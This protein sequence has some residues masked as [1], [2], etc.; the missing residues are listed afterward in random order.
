ML[1]S[2]LRAV[3]G[4]WTYVYVYVCVLYACVCYVSLLLAGC[5]SCELVAVL[6]AAVPCREPWL[7]CVWSPGVE[8]GGSEPWQS[9]GA[10]SECVR[11]AGCHVYNPRGR[12][13]YGSR[14]VTRGHT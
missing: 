12:R 6:Y 10:D 7:C 11:C 3:G 4:V 1:R 2:P 5:G 13:A 9:R 14:R 8:S